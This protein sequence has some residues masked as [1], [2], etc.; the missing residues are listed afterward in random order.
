[1]PTPTV[2]YPL[3]Q[4]EPGSP[5]DVHARLCLTI[6]TKASM[7]GNFTVHAD[8]LVVVVGLLTTPGVPALD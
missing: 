6:F 5:V 3:Q 1:M 8:R 7:G 4:D 2:Q